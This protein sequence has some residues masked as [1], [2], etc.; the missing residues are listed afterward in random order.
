MGSYKF[1]LA[2]IVATSVVAGLAATAAAAVLSFTFLV[3][4]SF[5]SSMLHD[6]FNS[7]LG[8]ILILDGLG[9]TFWKTFLLSYQFLVRHFW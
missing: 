4:V 8:P 9:W 3:A 6:I 7:V 1:K 5:S 2:L